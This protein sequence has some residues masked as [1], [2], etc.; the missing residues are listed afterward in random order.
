MS[1][2]TS[3]QAWCPEPRAIAPAARR[4]EDVGIAPLLERHR[5][6]DRLG[7]LQ[8]AAV[9]RAPAPP[10]PM[11]PMPGIISSRP[12]ERAHLL[13]LL[14]LVQEVL[15]GE[16]VRLQLLGELLAPASASNVSWARSI[17]VSTSPMP[18]MP[19]GQAVG[20]E[21]LERVGLLAGAQELD[22][23]AGDGARSRAPRRRAR[24]R[25]S[26]SGSGRSTARRRVK[27]SATVTASWPVIASTTSSVSAGVDAPAH[28]LESRPS[29][30]R[31]SCRRPAVS[32][33][34]TSRPVCLACGDAAC[35]RCRAR[36]CPSAARE[37]RDV[38][39]LAQRLEL[40]DGGRAVGV[41]GHQ[42]RRAALL[43]QVAGQLGGRS[44]SCPSPAGRP[45]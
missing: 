33:I 39:L 29:A 34:T 19:A 35:A 11:P 20:V 42:Q 41:G 7:A 30:P 10:W 40:V 24:R 21:G 27:A 13:D 5:L 31:R 45:A 38:E 4:V 26:W 3:G 23:H 9:D 15:E 8:L 14:H 1:R 25:R 16:A 32:R 18:R 44:S 22:R 6:D 2:L 36:A 12:A 17:S 28:A 43:A 37:D